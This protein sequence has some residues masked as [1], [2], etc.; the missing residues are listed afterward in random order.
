M[1]VLAIAAFLCA[2]LP[3]VTV[4]GQHTLDIVENNGLSENRIDLVIMGD[5]YTSGEQQDFASDAQNAIDH[6]FLKWPSNQYREFFNIVTISTASNESGADHPSM[7]EFA[8]TFYDC[9]YD[10]AGLEHLICCDYSTILSVAGAQYPAHDVVVLMVND[11]QYGGSGGTVAIASIS[12]VAKDIPFHEFGHTI[13]G[14]GDEYDSPYPGYVCE[15]IFPN[16]SFTSDRDD[17][18]WNHWV[19]EDTPLPTPESAAVNNLEPVGAYEGACYQTVGL[20]RP[21]DE[22]VMRS[23]NNDFCAVCT[24]QMVLS[25]YGFVEPV[26]TYSPSQNSHDGVFGDSIEFVVEAVEPDPNT[27]T[28]T[29]DLDGELLS[30][31]DSADLEFLFKCVDQG[32]H[33]LTVTVSDLTSMVMVDTKNLMTTSVSWTITR[34]DDGPVDD[35]DDLNAGVDACPD[36]G[37]NPEK[38]GCGCHT[39]PARRTL[40]S[41]LLALL[42]L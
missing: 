37:D 2:S 30:W 3:A 11:Q 14:L 13:A 24:E 9:A 26:D 23:L 16:I 4:Q 8:D 38:S 40:I 27:L 25:Y 39:I 32:E 7:S 33:Q 21:V 31:S 18:K 6:L 1:R 19:N 28:Y 10:C 5:G 17:L 15:D 36:G 12:P 42:F 35:C 22:C 34:T 20:F 29:W 41:S